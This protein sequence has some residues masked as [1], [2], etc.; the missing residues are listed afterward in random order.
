MGRSDII[1]IGSLL[2][3]WATFIP[4][5]QHPYYIALATN[6]K[7][8]YH[9]AVSVSD[10]QRTKP[11]ADWNHLLALK[12]NIY[13]NGYLKSEDPIRL[14]RINGYWCCVHGRHR[15]C[16]LLSLYGPNLTLIIKKKGTTAKIKGI[17]VNKVASVGGMVFS[18]R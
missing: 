13:H 6:N 9:Q 17:E 5:Y 16:I 11:S 3:K 1:T 10:K 2:I 12:F 4:I 8:L 18:F 7:D 14:Q 15:V